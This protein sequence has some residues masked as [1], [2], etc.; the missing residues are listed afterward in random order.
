[1]ALSGTS[2]PSTCHC[3]A[4]HV[5]YS[6]LSFKIF[7]RRNQVRSEVIEK[8]EFESRK[9]SFRN[10]LWNFLTMK[11][12]AQITQP[13]TAEIERSPKSDRFSIEIVVGEIK[14]EVQEKVE[15]G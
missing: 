15:F 3:R 4:Q 12:P 7:H 1:M 10:C 11:I 8:H 5:E 13:I 2:H 6:K 14:P 9:S